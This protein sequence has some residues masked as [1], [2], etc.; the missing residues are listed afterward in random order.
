MT[1]RDARTSDG[2]RPHVLVIDDAPELLDLYL[3]LL[4]SEGY[5]VTTSPATLTVD[6]ICAIAPDTIVH[7]LLFTDDAVDGVWQVLS[8]T[9]LD[10][11]LAPVPLIVSTA[12]SRVVNDD[13]LAVR[14]ETLAVPV[15]LK[16]FAID[17]LLNVLQYALEQT[18]PCATSHANPSHPHL[19]DGGGPVADWCAS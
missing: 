12:D 9:R 13:D 1:A 11:R 5:R 8:R 2:R 6:D 16:P 15:I 14:L 10:P 3:E 17:N 4:E 19:R 18:E 7:D